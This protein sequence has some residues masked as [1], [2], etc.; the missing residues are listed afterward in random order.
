MKWYTVNDECCQ[1]AKEGGKVLGRINGKLYEL[2]GD[3]FVKCKSLKGNPYMPDEVTDTIIQ[4]A[5]ML[6]HHL[7]YAKEKVKRAKSRL[8]RNGPFLPSEVKNVFTQHAKMLPH[9]IAYAKGAMQNRFGRMSSL[10]D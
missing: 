5:R 3:E 4:H 8:K 2:K 7:A 9:H 10:E 6:P 1:F